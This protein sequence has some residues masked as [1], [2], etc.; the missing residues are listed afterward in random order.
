[1]RGTVFAIALV[2]LFASHSTAMAQATIAMPNEHASRLAQCISLSTTGK[3]RLVTARWLAT[4]MAS[5]PLLADALSVNTGKKREIDIA[6]GALFTR[7]FTVDCRAE[8]APLFKNRDTLGIEAASGRLGEIAMKEL[9]SDPVA[10]VAIVEYAK[11]A[12]N[13]AFAKLVE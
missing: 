7:L 5:A 2:G 10:M 3:D 13:D 4:S 12:D 6:M 11:Y 1:M 8:A 9:M